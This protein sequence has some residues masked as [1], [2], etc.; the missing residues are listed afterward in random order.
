MKSLIILMSLFCATVSNAAPKNT[1]QML[2]CDGGHIAFTALMEIDHDFVA[3]KNAMLTGA[4]VSA[5][6]VCA[7]NKNLDGMKCAGFWNDKS[8]EL[9]EVSFTHLNG[10]IEMSYR[11]VTGKQFTENPWPCQIE[12]IPKRP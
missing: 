7:G 1:T 4:F 9:L 6:F 3:L 8:T 10:Y 12:E 2:Y 11:A 5:D